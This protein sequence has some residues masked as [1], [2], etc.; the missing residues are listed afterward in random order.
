MAT[1]LGDIW[2][3]PLSSEIPG[4]FIQA[5]FLDNILQNRTLKMPENQIWIV[6]FTIIAMVFLPLVL[7]ALF[8]PLISTLAGVFSLVGYAGTA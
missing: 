5:T 8:S 6:F 1:G 4:V 7:M 2:P 3:T